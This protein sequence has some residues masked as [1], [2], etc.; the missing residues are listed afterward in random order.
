MTAIELS[1]EEAAALMQLI[2]LAVKT[3]G[4]QVAEA[5]TVLARKIAPAT[6]DK[7]DIAPKE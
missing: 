4:L 2:D 6:A 3:G 7:P 1:K 5:A